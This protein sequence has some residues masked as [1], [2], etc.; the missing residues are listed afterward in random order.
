[1]FR[2][3]LLKKQENPHSSL[4]LFMLFV[5]YPPLLMI[6]GITQV[7]TAPCNTKSTTIYSDVANVRWVLHLFKEF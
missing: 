5:A 4:T 7:L 2:F 6:V 1:M 3:F